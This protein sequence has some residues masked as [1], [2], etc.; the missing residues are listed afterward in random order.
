MR[1]VLTLLLLVVISDPYKDI[2]YDQINVYETSYC[3]G[4]GCPDSGETY[5]YEDEESE[6]PERVIEEVKEDFKY[7]EEKPLIFP[8][9]FF[10][11]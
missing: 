10:S 4:Y 2:Q 8:V 9:D 1:F 6:E 7:E 11:A 5:N 3:H